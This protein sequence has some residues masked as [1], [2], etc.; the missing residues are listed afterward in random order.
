MELRLQSPYD[1]RLYRTVTLYTAFYID[2]SFITR[3]LLTVLR[4]HKCV[5]VCELQFVWREDQLRV[6]KDK[7]EETLEEL[8]D[9]DPQ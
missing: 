8:P 3:C 7:H 1:L 6:I 2:I 5:T 4:G 9:F